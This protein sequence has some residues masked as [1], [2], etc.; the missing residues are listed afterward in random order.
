MSNSDDASFVS[1]RALTRNDRSL[2]GNFRC[3]SGSLHEKAVEDRIRDVL[4]DWTFDS[5]AVANDPRTILLVDGS[6][7]ES[8]VAVA[9]HEVLNDFY[10]N[11]VL[12]EGTR[13]EVL[14]VSLD[15]RRT[16][17]AGQRI[18]DLAFNALRHDVRSRIPERGPLLLAAVDK[19]NGP[20][21]RLCERQGMRYLSDKPNWRGPSFI[22][23]HIGPA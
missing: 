19:N 14:A 12:C 17:V 20:S 16:T 9:A 22:E 15:R 8:L 13:I 3:S 7:P 4:F 18:G 11:G 1:V 2:L 5:H 6:D 10:S 21:L 23:Y